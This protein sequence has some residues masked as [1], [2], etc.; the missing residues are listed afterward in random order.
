MDGNLLGSK[1]R[2][3]TRLL[4]I[5]E[6]LPESLREE[7]SQTV[8]S[9]L[10][11]LIRTLPELNRASSPLT[12]QLFY[13]FASEVDLSPMLHLLPRS[14]HRVLLPSVS[15]SGPMAL[16]PYSPGSPMISGPF[17]IREP[18]GGR[19]VLP[20][21]V[22]LFLVPGLGFDHRGRRLGYGK[23]HFDRY[24]SR[25]GVRGIK[26]GVAYSEQILPEIPAGP[27]DVAMDFLVT[28]KGTVRCG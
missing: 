23:G 21:T 7:K 20:E 11:S 22:D 28:D 2:E 17:G 26:V 24:L 9:A 13:P 3:R 14:G 27:G 8:V 5:R 25:A 19:P 6:A 12:I 16:Y 18:E 4:S 15:R 1:Q 10:L